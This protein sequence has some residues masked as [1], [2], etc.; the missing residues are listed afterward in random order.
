MSNKV[1]EFEN[2]GKQYILGSIGTGTLS[3]D[4][5]RWW[6]QIR[7]R[8]DPFFKIGETNDR[9]QKSDS[10]IVWALKNINFDVNQG[11]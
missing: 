10:N 2:I 6:A 8:E 7:G 1:I 11:M 5:N 3:Q 4:L 9:T